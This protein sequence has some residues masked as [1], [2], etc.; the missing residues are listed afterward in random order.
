MSN[1]SKPKR[2]AILG[3]GAGAMAAAWGLTERPNWQDEY[4]ITVYQLGWRLGGKGASGRNMKAGGR[5]EEHGLHIWGGSYEN[6][7][8][9]IRK[10]YDQLGRDKYA[11]LATWDEAFKPHSFYTQMQQSDGKWFPWNVSYTTNDEVPGDGGIYLT[12]L[13]YLR[14]AIGSMIGMF[15][16]QESLKVK[17]EKPS[18]L[19]V[20]AFQWLDDLVR[21]PDK[22]LLHTVK[23]LVDDIDEHSSGDHGAIVSM[24]EAFM[25]WF[26]G[27]KE[28]EQEADDDA[29]LAMQQFNLLYATARGLVADG[30]IFNG[31]PSIDHLEY[32]EWLRQNGAW[33]D[34][35]N[36][37]VVRGTYDYMFG[38]ARGHIKDGE[39]AA[40]ACAHIMLR[41]LFT[42][43][44]S[45]FWKMQAGMGD[46]I[47]APIYELLKRQGVKFRFFHRVAN[48]GVSADKQSIE[49]INIS[50]Q[51]NL[52]A[53][54]DAEYDP[55]VDVVNLPCWPSDPLYDQIVEG[56]EL[57]ERGID[58]ESAWTPWQDTGGELTLRAGEDFDTVVLGISL[59]AF[60]DICPE[61][62]A[63]NQQWRDMVENIQTVQTQAMQLWLRPD[64]AG[65]GWEYP[66]TILTSYVEPMD[67][68]GDMSHLI[69]R[70]DWPESQ[71]PGS[72]AYFC[73]TFADA[74]EIPSP[75]TDPDFPVREKE[76]VKKIALEWLKNHPAPLWP[77]AVD[78]S[79]SELDYGLLIDQNGGEGVKRFDSQ[80]WRANINPTDRYVLS[81]PGTT[82]FRLKSGESG[83]GNLY[84]A[85]DWVR[86]PINAGCVEAAVMGGLMASQ[87]ICGYPEEIVG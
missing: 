43:K 9:M 16:G 4:E 33:E 3:G 84:L 24:L 46:T 11:P 40:G 31:F 38:F 27:M 58:L 68:W 81:I 6:A 56:K 48:L 35:L 85:G 29:R 2:I 74:Q 66:S 53:G 73:G 5:I 17:P 44:G 70:E 14:L 67:T 26:L 8:R 42:S 49:T 20:D 22:T 59:G 1:E 30:V 52:K 15:E 12:P 45:I 13:D 65:L 10:V 55:L 28:S 25:A 83:F 76:R 64:A 18:N 36:S 87:A 51:V 37:G 71:T 78:P 19:L 86:T 34:T 77:D 79:S 54:P 63:A 60:K 57:E 61:L 23:R 82:K 7:F 21:E 72:I 47:F 39:I 50:R 62:I 41:L 75:F 69:P 80:Y 32:R